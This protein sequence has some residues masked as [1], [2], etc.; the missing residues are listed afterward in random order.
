M[1]DISGDKLNGEF[2]LVKGQIHC[3]V[4]HLSNGESFQIETPQAEVSVVGTHF[5]VKEIANT[6]EVK[7]EEGIVKVLDKLH[8]LEYIITNSQFININTTN[9]APAPVANKDTGTGGDTTSALTNSETPANTGNTD[10]AL[11]EPKSY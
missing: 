1:K 11:K 10:E 2:N 9:I 4:Q 8:N 7:V 6:T 5:D 3:D